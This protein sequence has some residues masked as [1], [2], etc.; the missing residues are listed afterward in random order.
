MLFGFLILIASLSRLA[1][2]ELDKAWSTLAVIFGA[3]YAVLIGRNYIVQ[4]VYI[5]VIIES[6][7]QLAGLLTMV[8][9]ESISWIMEMFG[10]GFL[11]ISIWF[12]VPVFKT[13]G[14]QK[15][16]RILIFINGLASILG[17]V[18]TV[19]DI[20][21]VLS[22]IGL[23]NYVGWNLLI[24]ALMVFIFL[25]FRIKRKITYHNT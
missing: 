3:L 13:T 23:L 5:P 24:L 25:E 1:K 19:F 6:N 12:L 8:N 10:Y 18:I 11:G 17:A 7:T 15:L 2:T 16:V 9:P 14:R 22:P 20:T 21:W 4:I